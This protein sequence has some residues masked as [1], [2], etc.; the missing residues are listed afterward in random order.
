M[1]EFVQTFP[2]VLAYFGPEVQLPVL[3]FIAALSG[4]ILTIGGAPVRAIKQWLGE[5]KAKR[6]LS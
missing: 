4:L 1:A 3:S 6:T 2:T 5:R